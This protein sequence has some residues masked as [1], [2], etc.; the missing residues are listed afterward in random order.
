MLVSRTRIFLLLGASACLLALFFAA[1]HFYVDVGEQR[2]NVRWAPSVTDD[3]RLMLERRFGLREGEPREEPTWSYRLTNRSRTNIAALV[4]HPLVEDTHDIDRSA[5]R[6]QLDRPDLPQWVRALAEREQLDLL[7]WLSALAGV[8]LTVSGL[9]RLDHAGKAIAR[10]AARVSGLVVAAVLAVILVHDPWQLY[11][12]QSLSLAVIAVAVFFV[13]RALLARSARVDR[14]RVMDM[15]GRSY[16]RHLTGFVGLS[17]AFAVVFCWPLLGRLGEIGILND[18]DH[19]LVLHWVP[20]AT[21]AEYGQIPLWNPFVCGGMPMLG[22]LQSRWL[23]PFFLLHLASGPELGLQLEIVGHVAVAFAGAVVLGRTCGLSW[24]AAFAPA[25]AFA[26]CSY[27]YLHFAEGH[28]TWLA[29][30]YM[31]WILAAVAANRALLAGVG[32][33]LTFAEGGAYAVPHVVVALGLLTAYRSIAERS[34]RPLATLALA[35]IVAACVA[36]P[37]V[38]EALPVLA[39]SSRLTDPTEA[40]SLELV[41]RAL[42]DP[43]QDLWTPVPPEAR[44]GFHEYGAYVGP[45]PLVLALLGAF[46]PKR[47]ALPW[48]LICCVTAALAVGGTLGGTFSPWA[49]LHQLPVLASLRIPS[50]LLLVTVLAVGMLAGFGLDRFV[51]RDRGWRMA[52]AIAL[53]S[54]ATV[55]LLLVGPPNLQHLFGIPNVARERSSTFVQVRAEDDRHMYSL[56]R[57]NMGALTCYEPQRPGVFPAGVNEAGYRGE[58]YMLGSG[59]VKSVEWSPNRLRFAVVSGGPDVL[60]INSNYN[61]AWQVVSG[62]GRTVNHEGLLGVEVPAGSQELVIAYASTRFAIGLVLAIAAV[63]LGAWVAC[64]RVRSSARV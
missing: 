22:N 34:L 4:N 40:V 10:H 53:L 45:I 26:G 28:A 56:A 18:W 62:R 24:V 20:Y 15:D 39:H 27:W 43:R 38:L 5:F 16:V 37:K 12:P 41:A 49:L 1:L 42:L 2:V 61:E 47:V 63:C 52:V 25:T 58:Q 48:L 32:L 6:V 19:Q 33:A 8:V 17:L 54:T 9:R 60:V 11:A 51:R 55:D 36:A 64:R 59:H 7:A 23:T 13:S 44:Y 30:A 14:W 46:A 21:V 35:G 50:R 29:Y 3:T 31:P 57:A